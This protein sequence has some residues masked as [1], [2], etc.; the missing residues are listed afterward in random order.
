LI[1]AIAIQ[2]SKSNITTQAQF[3]GKMAEEKK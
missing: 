1:K 3:L 2:T